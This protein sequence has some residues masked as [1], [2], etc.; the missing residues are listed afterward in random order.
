[1]VNMRKTAGK[2]LIWS[3]CVVIVMLAVGC[4]EESLSET[5]KDIK[6]SRLIAMKNKELQNE[7]A[8]CKSEIEKLKATTKSTNEVINEILSTVITQNQ[9]LTKENKELK[10][11]LEQLKKI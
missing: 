2:L 4:E 3:V 8:E 11:K 7:L 5:S 6:K 1:M 10:K 9:I